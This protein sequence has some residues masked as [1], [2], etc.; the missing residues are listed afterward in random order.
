MKQYNHA[1]REA[2]F[3]IGR[4]LSGLGPIERIA[5]TLALC[6]YA[7]PGA[8]AVAVSTVSACVFLPQ[9]AGREYSG[10]ETRFLLFLQFLLIGAALS[11]GIWTAG[12]VARSSDIGATG[13]PEPEIQAVDVILDADPWRRSDG[14]W[15][16][17]GTISRL[18]ADWA[19]VDAQHTSLLVGPGLEY[20][21]W[22]NHVHVRTAPVRIGEGSDARFFLRVDHAELIDHGHGVLTVRSRL[23]GLIRDRSGS[24]P[25]ETRGVYM[26]LFLGNRDELSP[27]LY[28]SVRRAGAA[29]VLALSGMHLG[30]IAGAFVLLMSPLRSRGLT[31]AGVSLLSVSYLVL[32]G[33]RPS[34]TRAVIMLHAALF[35]RLREG[36]VS[37]LKTLCLTFIAHAAIL[38]G[39]TQSLGFTLSFSALLGIFVLTP[40]LLPLLGATRH[41]KIRAGIAAGFAAQ[42]ATSTIAWRVFGTVYP[43]GAISSLMFT[44]VAAMA[45]GF[46]SLALLPLGHLATVSLAGLHACVWAITLLADVISRV[47]GFSSPQA[48]AGWLLTPAFLLLRVHFRYHRE[49]RSAIPCHHSKPKVRI[50]LP[51]STTHLRQYVRTLK[52]EAF[53]PANDS[54]RTSWSVRKSGRSSLPRSGPLQEAASGRSGPG[55]ER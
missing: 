37:G 1:V 17:R 39:D 50:F 42:L 3:R 12:R 29:H 40:V 22:G 4:L 6:I 13:I 32:A 24:W 27:F 28:D 48:L 55:S 44:P 10:R 23:H 53:R 52:N 9:A 46:G 7:S 51:A 49:T 8:A 2:L 33:F 45:L 20:L 21:A 19:R 26:A 25:V 15:A 5:A 34:L 38:P 11:L 30:L 43:V 14:V 35:L 47:P 16:A 41:T 31:A 36:R 18:H 54:G